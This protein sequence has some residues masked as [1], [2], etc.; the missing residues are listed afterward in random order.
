M[1]GAGAGHELVFTSGTTSRPK[2]VVHTHG[3]ALWSAKIG[4][5]NI[6][7]MEGDKYLIYLP[8]FHVNA[9]S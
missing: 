5:N 2:A 6:D 8:F 7:L 4:P 3:N 1:I 9:Q